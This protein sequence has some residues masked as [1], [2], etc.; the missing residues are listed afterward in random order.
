MNNAIWRVEFFCLLPLSRV[1][2]Q[3]IKKME[4][5]SRKKHISAAANAIYQ[6]FWLSQEENI[7]HL[8]PQLH[9]SALKVCFEAE[10]QGKFAGRG[11]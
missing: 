7:H 1:C 11:S 9:P 5:A 6:P 10:Y 8:F 2:A 3:H 4:K